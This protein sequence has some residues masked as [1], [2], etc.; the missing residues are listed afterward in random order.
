MRASGGDFQKLAIHGKS[1]ELQ[2][3]DEILSKIPK[4]ESRLFASHFVYGLRHKLKSHLNK[5]PLHQ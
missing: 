5:L 1:V 3:P 2:V 4:L